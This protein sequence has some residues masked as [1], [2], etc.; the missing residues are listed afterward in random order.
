MFIVRL[1]TGT[2]TS[3]W[4]GSKSSCE[5]KKKHVMIT[6]VID[7]WKMNTKYNI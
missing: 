3:R 7:R 4:G 6:A 2:W 5:E 1:V